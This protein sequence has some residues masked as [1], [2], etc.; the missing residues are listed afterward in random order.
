MRTITLATLE[1][2]RILLDKYC[3]CLRLR[4]REATTS[5]RHAGGCESSDDLIPDSHEEECGYRK[6]NDEWEQE[7]SGN[8]SR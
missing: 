5:E 6:L 8:E 2:W 3:T 1:D 4:L 7:A